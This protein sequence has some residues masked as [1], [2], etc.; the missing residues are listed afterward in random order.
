MIRSAKYFVILAAALAVTGCQKKEIKFSGRVLEGVWNDVQERV[1]VTGIVAGAKVWEEMEPSEY[2]VS[3]ANGEY[4]LV[5]E[6]PFTIGAM[7]QK[8]Y[9]LL[10]SGVNGF[11]DRITVYGIMGK[12]NQVRDFLLY[13]HNKE[14]WQ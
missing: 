14:E 12:T 5:L 10:A 3:D 2:A 7:P 8:E 1:D 9:K 11:D 6:A 4:T 13:E